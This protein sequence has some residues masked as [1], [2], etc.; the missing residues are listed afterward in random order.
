M[1]ELTEVLREAGVVRV[2]GVVEDSLTPFL[3]AVRRTDGMAWVEVRDERLPRSP[4]RTR[5]K[6]GARRRSA[7]AFMWPGGRTS[8]TVSTALTEP[9]RPC[10]QDRRSASYD[11]DKPTADIATLYAPR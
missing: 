10:N 3:D 9:A 5:P 8:S 1:T 2:Y 7:R 6:P 11:I 4:R